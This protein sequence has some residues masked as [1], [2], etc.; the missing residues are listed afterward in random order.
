[1]SALDAAN[2]AWALHRRF[3]SLEHIIAG[4]ARAS[5]V[6]ARHVLGGKFKLG[7][8]SIITDPEYACLYAIRVLQGNWPAAESII[9]TDVHY[10]RQYQ[11]F[12]RLK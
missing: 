2:V 9:A 10:W 7:E 8:Y 3:P 4:D 11:D 1:M 5:F 12:L 6:Y